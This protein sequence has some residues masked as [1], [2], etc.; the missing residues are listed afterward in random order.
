MVVEDG[1][2]IQLNSET[3]PLDLSVSSSN[4]TLKEIQKLL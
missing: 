2:L 4:S 3:S 1:K